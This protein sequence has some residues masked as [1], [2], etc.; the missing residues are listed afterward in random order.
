MLVTQVSDGLNSSEIQVLMVVHSPGIGGANKKVWLERRVTVASERMSEESERYFKICF[1]I[2][3]SIG[4][5]KQY[6]K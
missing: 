1:G 6:R 2:S 5:H 4:D 3:T